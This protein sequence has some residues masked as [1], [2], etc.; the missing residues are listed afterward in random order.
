MSARATGVEVASVDSCEVLD[1]RGRPTVWCEVTLSGGARGSASVPSGAS[2]SVHE[3]KE[4]RDGGKRYGGRGTR[5][6]VGNVRSVLGPA[7]EGLDASDQRLVDETLVA[8]DGTRDLS[9]LGA[10]A[11]LAVSVATAIAAANSAGVEL[12]QYL[13]DRLG[14]EPL[15]PLPMVNVL[16]GG[17]HAGGCID[18]QD[19]LVVPLGAANFAE[20][21][22]WAAAVREATRGV[23]SAGG[24]PA[25]L[26]AD[27]GGLG[28]A[29]NSNRAALDLLCAGTQAAGFSLGTDVVIAI[30]VAAGQLATATGYAFRSEGRELSSMELV[31]EVVGWCVD[32]PVASVEDPLSEDDWAAWQLAAERLG[33]KA[34]LLGDDLFA[35]D[36]ERVERGIHARAAT[37]V[38]VKPNQVGTLTGALDVVQRARSAGLGT[39]VSARSGETEDCWLADLAVG[40]G[41]GQIKVGSTTRAERTSKWNRL[42]R[43]EHVLGGGARYAGAGANPLALGAVHVF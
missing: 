25:D 29:L 33:G 3:R 41:A 39:V 14:L 17:A 42:L 10:N 9:R 8:A 20:A 12:Y 35:T 21:I 6:A 5:Q 28:L 27:E 24:H 23:A 13:A 31:D 32:Y 16:S 40:W 34:Q 11:V 2:T 4:L 22:E 37:A 19:F 7:L 26:A 1:S 36:L 18:V 38:L 15:L 30:D 43:I